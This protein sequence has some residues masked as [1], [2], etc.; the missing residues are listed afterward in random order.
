MNKPL[1]TALIGVGKIGLGYANDSIM[2]RYWKYA[3]HAQ[4]LAENPRIKWT[5]AIDPDKSARRAA[6]E[7][8]A[9]RALDGSTEEGL[10]AID[11]AV[12]AT[13]TDHRI[14]WI[15]R[16]TNLKAVLVEKPLGNNLAQ[17]QDLIQLCESRG[18]LLQVNYWRRADQLFRS[19]ADGA[20][21]SLI[22]RPQTA[23][24]V[25][26]GGLLNNG[27]H[28]L[29]TARMLLGEVTEIRALRSTSPDTR[30]FMT[31]H[32]SGATCAFLP[33]DFKHYRE[34]GWEIWGESGHLEVNRA[35]TNIK[36]CTVGDHRSMA[37][38]REVIFE[39]PTD[40]QPTVGTSIYRMHENL[41][42]SY[43]GKA[44]L[45]SSGHSAFETERLL[46]SLMEEN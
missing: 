16:L 7:F 14:A 17:A 27:S 44:Q 24:F 5:L 32:D 9:S 35:A 1:R 46:N 19:W 26:G 15:E 12:L 21:T 33:L 13:P 28:M 25:Y 8:G 41:I 37:G 2:E 30:A 4:V 6:L 3:S 45:W 31:A 23:R 40:I 20:L 43:Q 11:Y 10:D 34:L 38:Q 29:D 36:V 42:D 18:I 22:G 39:K